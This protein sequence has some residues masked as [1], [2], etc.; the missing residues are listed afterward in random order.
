MILHLEFYQSLEMLAVAQGAES[1]DL[2][3]TIGKKDDLCLLLSS[4]SCKLSSNKNE[5]KHR[6]SEQGSG[7]QQGRGAGRVKRV[8]C[9]VTDGTG[10]LPWGAPCSV[11]TE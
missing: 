6:Y 2:R 7:S 5:N 9:M 1:L 10:L 8:S 3:K 4:P 11:Y